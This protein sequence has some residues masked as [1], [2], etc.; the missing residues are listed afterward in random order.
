[1]KLQTTLGKLVPQ[2]P[3]TLHRDASGP[4]SGACSTARKFASIRAY[5]EWMPIRQVDASDKLRIW[6]N[7][8]IGKLLDLTTLDT[9][10]LTDLLAQSAWVMP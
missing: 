5:H 9:R 10:E 8:K 3:T 1:M 4:P 6:K 7:F 2:I